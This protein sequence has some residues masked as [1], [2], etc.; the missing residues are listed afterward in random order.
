MNPSRDAVRAMLYRTHWLVKRHLFAEM[1]LSRC[2]CVLAPVRLFCL[3]F[4]HLPFLWLLLSGKTSPTSCP[5]TCTFWA[6]G[7]WQAIYDEKQRYPKQAPWILFQLHIVELWC[8]DVEPGV[9][10]NAESRCATSW[11][12]QNSPAYKLSALN[13]KIVF[14][15]CF[16]PKET[17]ILFVSRN[18]I[19]GK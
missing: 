2:L 5:Q 8:L 13:R 12:N 1:Y 16:A 9:C 10:W 15:K 17:W 18:I 11:A 6:I 3:L 7:L 14:K 4:F 19:S